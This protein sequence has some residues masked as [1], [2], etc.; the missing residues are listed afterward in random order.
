MSLG[1]VNLIFLKYGMYMND[2]LSQI[3]A[4]PLV[5]VEPKYCFNLFEMFHIQVIPASNEKGYTF[6]SHPCFCYSSALTRIKERH[7]QVNDS[8]LGLFRSPKIRAFYEQIVKDRDLSLCGNC[9]K[10][11]SKELNGFATEYQMCVYFGRYG[12]HLFKHYENQSFDPL[13]IDDVV[14]DGDIVP[15]KVALNLDAACNLHCPTCR[16]TPITETF[17]ITDQDIQECIEVAK[18]SQY[19]IIGSDGELFM[20]PNYK[21]ILT[22]DFSQS[23]IKHIELYTNGTILTERKWNDYIHKNNEK[24]ISIIKVSVDAATPETY[25][26]VRGN[27][28][29]ALQTNLEFLRQ[30]KKELGFEMHTTFTISKLNACD[31]T[32]FVEAAKNMGFDKILFSFARSQFHPEG[33]PDALVIPED[34]RADIKEYLQEVASRDIDICLDF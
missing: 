4:N 9:P 14:K 16:T 25:Q 33:D 12:A 2:I 15:Y 7:E 1:D 31:V 32:K 24:L 8:P 3:K 21:R 30:K 19:L 26:K 29:N 23:S 28:W 34:K 27:H 20:S 22:T 10:Y 17:K 5:Y 11:Q 18:K 6:Y 13:P